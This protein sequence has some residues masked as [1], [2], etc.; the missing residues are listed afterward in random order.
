MTAI[1]AMLFDLDGTLLDSAPDLVAALN[2]VRRSERL[3]PLA[4]G[5]M[6]RFASKGAVGLLKAGMPRADDD[7]FESW[8]QR[9]LE[10][11]AENS[12]RDSALYEGVPEL[13][14]FLGEMEIPW[15]IVTNKMEAL[16]IPIV[17][18]AN[19]SDA[20]SCVVCGDTL[21]ES[22]PHPAPVNL[23]CAMVD[24]TPK[25]VLFVGDDVRDIQAGR[26]AGTQTAAA[27]YGYGSHELDDDIVAGSFRVHHPAEL[28]ELVRKQ[29]D[30]GGGE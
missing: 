21:N 28:I 1:R 22:K 14:A 18:A 15:G 17:E 5:D 26:A 8:R 19:L 27:F 25:Q 29:N 6:Q 11:Y 4:V 10:H 23:A 16:T 24:V 3:P 9:F 30:I 12:Y 13:L 20:I 2:W 7:V